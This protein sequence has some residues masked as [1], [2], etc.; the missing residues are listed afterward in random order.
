MKEGFGFIRRQGA[1]EAL[2]VLAFCMT[3]LGVPMRDLPAGV[4]QD[5]FHQGPGTCTPCFCPSSG[6]RLRLGALAVA[7]LGNVRH[8]AGSR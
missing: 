2:M 6:S 1:M 8:K 3:A 4:R 7:G 5:I